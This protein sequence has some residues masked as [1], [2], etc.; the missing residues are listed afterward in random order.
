MAEAGE[1]PALSCFARSRSGLKMMAGP[2][3]TEGNPTMS[4]EP[5]LELP[6][7]ED[8][9]VRSEYSSE[10]SLLAVPSSD[11]IAIVQTASNTVVQQIPCP[12]AFAV[13]LS[14]NGSFLVAW[15]KFDGKVP[16]LTVWDVASGEPIEAFMQKTS[17]RDAWPVIFWSENEDIAVRCVTNEVHLYQGRISK[18]PEARLRVPG[19]SGVAFGPGAAP[20]KLGVHTPPGKQGE[21]G[22]AKLYCFQ[23]LEELC[24]PDIQ[25]VAQ[26]SFFRADSVQWLWSGNGKA[27][28]VRTDCERDTQGKSYYGES[29]L[30]YMTADG[31]ACNSIVLDKEGPIHDIQWAPSGRNF[32]VIYG[33]VPGKATLF[34][35]GCRPMFEFGAVA[36]NTIRWSPHGRFLCLAGFGSLNGDMDFWDMNKLKK[37]GTSNSRYAVTANWSPDSRFF[38]TAVTFPRRRVDNCYKVFK[39]NG[40]QIQ[41]EAVD[42]LYQFDWRCARRGV[43]PDRPQSP[44]QAGAKCAEAAA[45]PAKPGKYVPPSQR[46]RGGE[47]AAN[48]VAAQLAA[49]RGV[50]DAN[51]TAGKVQHTGPQT[52]AAIKNA[53]KREAKKRAAEAKTVQADAAPPADSKPAAEEAP[54][55]VEAATEVDPEEAKRK[56][57]RALEKKLK[58]VRAL[59]DKQAGGTELNEAQMAKL[60]KEKELLAQVEE[61][62]M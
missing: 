24:S 19:V 6:A 30:Y 33:F 16:N 39:Y 37:M 36:H 48:S 52:A 7:S 20:F 18:M 42:E 41:E 31:K 45:A 38:A 1:L 9:H 13:Q 21:P 26:T 5:L 14:P 12:G 59:K 23:A 8:P 43:Y 4:G 34:G 22:M 10:G 28:I 40:I 2:V 60:E 11:A 29:G 27:V 57:I 47:E 46:G 32:V 55:V 51:A 61:L 56:K 50:N 15:T 49:M 3:V 44:S 62:M 54:A 35:D 25:P 58:E 17:P 53:K